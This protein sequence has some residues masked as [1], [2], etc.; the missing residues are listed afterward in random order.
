MPVAWLTIRILVHHYSKYVYTL[1][2]LI[3]LIALVVSIQSYI[4]GYTLQVEEVAKLVKYKGEAIVYTYNLTPIPKGAYKDLKN[5]KPIIFTYAYIKTKNGTIR[6]IAFPTEKLKQY[7]KIIVSSFIAKIMNIT[8][9]TIVALGLKD[10]ILFNTKVVGID[11]RLPPY[12]I[13]I[14]HNYVENALEYAIVK[15]PSPPKSI[16]GVYVALPGSAVSY[17]RAISRMVLESISIILVLAIII[18][19]I[20][21]AH[22]LLTLSHEVKRELSLLYSIGVRRGVLKRII[23][24]L[25]L[26]LTIMSTIIG[27][28]LGIVLSDITAF[29]SMIMVGGYVKPAITFTQLLTITLLSLSVGVIATLLSTVI[30][31]RKVK[32]CIVFYKLF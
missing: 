8:K 20:G 16:K 1:L 7:N 9:N 14:P 29:T 32:P 23:L 30:V 12:A 15:T 26:T 13:L 5:Y 2:S 3:L 31:S 6:V 24:M 11:S 4:Q 10:N 21:I 17:T 27:I 22:I 18:E 28:S 25:G 19:F